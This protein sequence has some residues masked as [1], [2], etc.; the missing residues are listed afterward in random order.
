MAFAMTAP[1]DSPERKRVPNAA[2]MVDGRFLHPFCALNLQ[3]TPKKEKVSGGSA[4]PIGK[5]YFRQ[6]NPRKDPAFVFDFL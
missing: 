5:A 1:I 6:G 2:W 3:E 4:Q